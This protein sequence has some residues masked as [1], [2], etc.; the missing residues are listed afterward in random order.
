MTG[1][2]GSAGRVV[3]VDDDLALRAELRTLLEDGGYE[4]VGEASD[5]IAGLAVA[6]RVRPDVVI[7]DLKMP[8]YS[9]LQLAAALKGDLPVVVL[10]AFDDEGLQAEARALGAQFLVKGCRSQRIFEAVSSCVPW[11]RRS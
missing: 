2:I 5:A 8:G 6:R 1:S 11:A 4:V 3:L 9:G 7:T 10:S